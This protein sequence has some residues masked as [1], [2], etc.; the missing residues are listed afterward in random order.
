M[1]VCVQVAAAEQRSVVQ[2]LPSS[3][4]AERGPG[5]RSSGS[6]PGSEAGRHMPSK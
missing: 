1:G 6:V 5:G 3:H 2:T 4:E